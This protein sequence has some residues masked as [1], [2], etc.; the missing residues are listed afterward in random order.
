MC[1]DHR[2]AV[3]RLETNRRFL[4]FVR[5]AVNFCR[6]EQIMQESRGTKKK[7]ALRNVQNGDRDAGDEIQWQIS[8]YIVGS[9]LV[10][11]RK[12]GEQ[13][14][15]EREMLGGF[16]TVTTD[17]SGQFRR[18]K[19]MRSNV[20][21]GPGDALIVEI[22]V[23]RVLIVDAEAG[24]GQMRVQVLVVGQVQRDIGEARR[25]GLRVHALSGAF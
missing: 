22:V 7:R 2:L 1:R 20:E 15:F 18:V 17:L 9:Q 12:H 8:F 21:I 4:W 19:S 16:C 3:Y 14:V 24:F 13:L 11:Q 25:I 10:E 23:R 6:R 5:E